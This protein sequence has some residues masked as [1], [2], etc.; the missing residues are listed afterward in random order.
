MLVFIFFMLLVSLIGYRV[1][2][3]QVVRS[4][5]FTRS[6]VDERMQENIVPA[7]RG[8]IFDSHGVRL[9]T[10]VPASRISVIVDQIPDF[11]ALAQ[12]LSPLIGRA[13]SDIVDALA[14]PGAEWVV[15]A[16]HLTPEVSDQIAA[17]KIPGIVLDP[18]P[19]RVYP[20]GDFLSQVLGFT[21]YDMQGNYGIEGQYDGMLG[22]E[23]GKLVGER[24]GSG[25]VIAVTQSTWDPPVDGSDVTLTINS[26]VQ[27]AIE[28]ILAD[29]VDKQN[30]KGGTIIVQDP[31][32]G[33]I[34]GMASSPGYDPNNFNDV[35]DASTFLNPAI[36]A[37][38]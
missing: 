16:R 28:K 15:L 31:D 14:Q 23:P 17:M 8:E 2:A 9:A 4:S 35:Q 5:E 24:D 36:S 6:A 33:A 18:E 19:S 26:A 3:V 32:T 12:Q 1:V 10:N 25:N 11:N 37:I 29:T 21:N 27:E 13:P 38:Y 7:R 30:A 34:I 20:Y 22:G